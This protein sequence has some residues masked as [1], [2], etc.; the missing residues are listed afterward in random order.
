MSAP[1]RSDD[2]ARIDAALDAAAEIFARFTAGEVEVLTKAGGD[3]VTEADHAIDAA[4]RGLLPRDGEGWLSEETA[5]DPSRLERQRVWV[6]DPLDGTKEFVQGI[7]EFVASIGLVED[8]EPVAGGIFNPTT[9]E[10]FLGARGLG[11]RLGGTPVSP[12]RRGDLEGATV[13]ASRSETKRGEWAG[14]G[15]APFVVK[16][17]GSVAYKLA[18]V[19]AGLDD[20]TWTLVPKSEWDVAAGVALVEAAGGVTWEWPGGGRRRFNAASPKLTG[21]VA[22][23]TGLDEAVRGFL[24]QASGA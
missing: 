12:S 21:L 24:A 19:A 13:L 10:R 17:M 16:P 1:D 14:F 11:V 8:G 5:D 18:R 15:Q 2:L 7:P 9:G 4:L 23:P 20:I 3:P 6:V 22:T